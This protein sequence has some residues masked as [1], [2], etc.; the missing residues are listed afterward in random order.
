M[1]LLDHLVCR[2][3]G[4]PI[5]LI[6]AWKYTCGYKRQRKYTGRDERLRR[7]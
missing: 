2:F 6:G 1:K 4:E 7:L 3:C 5:V